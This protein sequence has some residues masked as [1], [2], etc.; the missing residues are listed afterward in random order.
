MFLHMLRPWAIW[1][2]F[3]SWYVFCTF[4]LHYQYVASAWYSQTWV[5]FNRFS[6]YP[7][8]Q[9]LLQQYRFNLYQFLPRLD[10][11][12]LITDFPASTITLFQTLPQLP[13]LWFFFSS[14]Q[15]MP[16][17]YKCFQCLLGDSLVKYACPSQ[18]SANP[19]IYY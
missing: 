17:P 13:P 16:L 6:I 7:T 3:Y 4:P 19:S 8:Y 10:S 5:L 14:N 12:I 2:Y 18:S 1:I 15:S 11:K 9:F